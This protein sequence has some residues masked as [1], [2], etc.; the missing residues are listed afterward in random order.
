MTK[1]R[2]LAINMWL[3]IREHYD[4]WDDYFWGSSEGDGFVEVVKMYFLDEE[5]EGEVPKWRGMCWLCQYVRKSVPTSPEKFFVCERCP[6][7]T[8]YTSDSAYR[9]LDTHTYEDDKHVSKEVYRKCCTT[10]L[11][12]LGYKGE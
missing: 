9:I 10:I 8:C 1:E 7:K 5:N 12:A 2:K 11:K 4:D 3:W 6:L